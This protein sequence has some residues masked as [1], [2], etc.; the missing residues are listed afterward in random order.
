M[1]RPELGTKR[2]CP[3]TG[4][5][6]YDLDRDPVV[7]PYTGVAYPRSAFEAVGLKGG[8][9][10]PVPAAEEDE[11]EE[12]VE[13]ADVEL[14]SLEDADADVAEKKTTDDEDI[15][16]VDDDEADDTFLAEEEEGDDDDVS[17]LIDGDIEDEE[18]G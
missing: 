9:V 10:L 17:D 11:E 2:T 3:E 13:K 1:A 4:R 16:I 8:R 7:S 6:F 12:I 14:V 18:E 5:K 15:D